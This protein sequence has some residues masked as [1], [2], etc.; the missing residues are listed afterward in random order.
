[1]DR[2]LIVDDNPANLKLLTSVLMAQGYTVHPASDGKLALRFVRS[3]LPDLILLDIKMPGMDGYEVCRRLKADERTHGVPIIFIS[4]L[5]D[6]GEKV[7][8]FQA[9][10]VDY[11]T[12]PFQPEEVIARVRLHLRLRELTAHLENTVAARTE[13]LMLA[14]GR[15]EQELAERRKAEEALRESEARLEAAQRLA[16]V[17]YW[18]RDLDT[19]HITRLEETYRI[20][21]LLRGEYPVPPGSALEL[22][23]PD[24]RRMMLDALAE[25]LRGGRRYDLDYRVIL[26]DGE[27]RFVHSQG[28][29]IRDEAGRPQRMFGTAQDVTARKRAEQRL[30]AQHAVARILAEA[31]TLEEA[32]PKI[33]QAVCECLVWDMG[34]LW[35]IDRDAGVLRCA[36]LWRR[37]SLEAT[38]FEA[39]TRV[40]AFRPGSGLPGRVW[41]SRTPACISDVVQDP[42][43]LRANSAMVAELHSA[44]AFPILLGSEVLGVIDFISREVRQPDQD[45]LDVMATIGSQIGQFIERKRAE[46]AL[47]EAEANLTHVT[48]VTLLG[49]LAASIAHEVNQPLAAMVADAHA[50]LNWLAQVNP[51][52]KVVRETL[53]SIV[54]DGHQAA[55]VIQRIRRLMKKSAGFEKVRLDVNELIRDVLPLVRGEVLRHRVALR[56]DLASE[57]PPVL[58]DRVQLQQVFTNLVMNG[59]EA[60]ASVHD[61]PRE[62]VLRSQAHDGEEVH[63]MVTDVGIGIDPETADRMFTAFFTTKPGGMGMGLSITRSIIEAH[64][65]R[66]WATANAPHGAIFHLVLP[67][68]R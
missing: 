34:A 17:G 23:H 37:P 64:G 53:A 18:D 35:R 27:V 48:R 5:E 33:L 47:D 9:G 21:G 31:T 20:H 45:L 1:M 38:Q 12:K 25:A 7:K 43:F 41:A 39:A 42:D 54:A 52:L 58:A 8:G 49:E 60:M 15:L 19:E 4:I 11:V 32:T 51:D 59:L 29:V 63:V 55:D 13:E 65:G 24:D 26:P 62:L 50:C 56:L 2:I 3:I 40:I 22:V 68:L 6:E 67:R 36:E 16:H 46:R 28:D 14:N 44:F 30:R 57:L 66:I 61:R 10:A